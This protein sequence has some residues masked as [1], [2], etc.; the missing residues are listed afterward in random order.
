MPASPVG[1]LPAPV[2]K[3]WAF[4]RGGQIPLLSF[5]RGGTKGVRLINNSHN[6]QKGGRGF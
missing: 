5:K 1:I 2:M 4:S 6:G 3:I